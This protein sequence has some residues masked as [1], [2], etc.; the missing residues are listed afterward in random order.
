MVFKRLDSGNQFRMSLFF[1]P[2]LWNP[3][4]N[5]SV[6]GLL[7]NVLRPKTNRYRKFVTCNMLT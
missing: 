6:V 4:L 3:T 7:K 2:L 1:S 5:N